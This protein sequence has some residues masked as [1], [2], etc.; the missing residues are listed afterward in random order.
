MFSKHVPRRAMSKDLPLVSIALCT[1][2]GA[3]YLRAQLDSLLAQTYRNIEIIALDDGSSDATLDIL[4]EYR[5]CDTRLQVA[6]NPRNLG[7][8][9]NFERA[10]TMCRG[11]FIAPCD[12]DDIWLPEKLGT[13][14]EALGQH[15][16]AYCDSEFVDE[17]GRGLGTTMSDNCTMVSSDDPIIFAAAN[18]VAGHAML[19]RRE[20]VAR[21]LPIPPHF[22]YDWWL[23]AVAASADGVVYCD[24][25]LVKYR[26][27]AHNA[28]NHLREQPPAKRRG[29]RYLQLEQFRLRL[30]SLAMLPGRN[31]AV[32]ER[33]RDLWRAR[34]QQ[35]ISPALALFIFR[36][37]PR[38]FALQRP[39][40]RRLQH[41]LKFS[42]GLRS[43]RI[44]N[45]SAYARGESIERIEDASP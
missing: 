7:L 42:I 15:S 5:R 3:R 41:A 45:P 19:V 8:A 18:C 37:G 44:S 31:R 11:D 40:P 39:R 35:W 32:I 10:I 27:H 23:A 1:F 12:Q 6:S 26:L 17:D 34:E 43:K 38:I 21:A 22:Y 20:I 14:Y 33:L 30:E 2:N 13:L 36:H 29:H 28:T 9:K 16:L 25:P 4:N 24:R